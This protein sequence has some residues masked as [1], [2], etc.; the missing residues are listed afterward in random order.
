V[1]ASSLFVK[2]C[3]ITTEGDALLAAALGAD[4]VGLV[5]AASSR[6]VTS[7]RA[8]DIVRLL[9]PYVL[10]VGVF[11][12]ESRERVVE[13]ANTIGLR[14]VQLHGHENPEDTRWVAERVPNVIRAFSI[15]DPA[16]AP[17]RLA[18]YGPVQVLIDSPL[19]GSGEPFDWELLDRLRI[20]RGFVLAGGL[21][22]DNV[23]LA[24]QTVR[25]WGVDVSSGVEAR[26]GTK[27][28][29]KVRQ[30]IANARVA[31]ALQADHDEGRPAAPYDWSH[32]IP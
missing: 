10:S 21:T 31:H 17:A 30:F 19:P 12:N 29:V 14:V 7:G 3:G 22:A 4:A 18:E 2:I 27:D 15:G 16:L 26:P 20:G 13:T 5:F 25:P 28:P 1:D 23:A 6:R 8:R 11:R 32:E 9:P 24:V